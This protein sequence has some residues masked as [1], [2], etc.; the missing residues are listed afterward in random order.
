MPRTNRPPSYRLHKARNCAVV[1]V[2]GK[3]HYLGPYGSPESHEQ[4]A[5]LIA[6]WQSKGRIGIP[7]SHPPGNSLSLNELILCYW[8]HA[9]SYYVKHD[10]PTDEQAGIRSALRFVRRQYGSTLADQFGPLKLKAVREAMIEAGL[11]RGVINQYVNRIRRMFRWGVENELIPVEVYQALLAVKGL[12]KGRSKARETEPVKPVQD[13][14]VEATLRH[15]TRVVCA[16]VQLQR[17]TGCRP[18]DVCIVRPCD[19]ETSG[20]VWC[21]RPATFKMEHTCSQ[22]KVY[23]GPQAQE[24]LRPWLD[25][26]PDAYCFNPREA[27]EESIARR[28]RN[29]AKRS[30]PGKSLESGRP[31]N[32][33]PGD[34]YTRFSY[35][36]AIE[37]ACKR[38][39]VPKWTPNQLRHSRATEVREQY[40]LEG[41]QTAL[42]HERANV[43]EIYA[44]RNDKLARQIAKETG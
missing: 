6:E 18:K 26:A 28:R 40:G 1:T 15:L 16:M 14:R 44:E 33:A 17:L 27:T 29:G 42:G 4:Y 12:A 25:R 39:G 13:E 34:R 32:R 19:V 37:R 20:D 36:Q 7:S 10:L 2:D 3:N 21:Y 30:A 11:S 22:R 9:R 41:S 24:V 43:T 23:L 35:R 38:A 31:R 8:K 5:Q